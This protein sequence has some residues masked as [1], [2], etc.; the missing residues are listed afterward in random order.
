MIEYG[1]IPLVILL[2]LI[3]AV[4]TVFNLKVA[5]GLHYAATAV[6]GLVMLIFVFLFL[7]NN[8]DFWVVFSNSSRDLFIGYKLMA[9]FTTVEG[10]LLGMLF[11]MNL[12]WALGGR[13]IKG[14]EYMES[15]VLTMVTLISVLLLVVVVYINP[16]EHTSEAF[17]RHFSDGGGLA[18]GFRS[19]WMIVQPA[20]FIIGAGLG[21]LLFCVGISPILSRDIERFPHRF[22]R[23]TALTALGF[24]LLAVVLWAAWAHMSWG[25]T[26]WSF[27]AYEG[28]MVM[29][30]LFLVGAVHAPLI[31]RKGGLPRSFNLFLLIPFISFL[32][33]AYLI[34]SGKWE[35]AMERDLLSK[36]FGSPLDASWLI[37]T[38]AF[39]IMLGGAWTVVTNL[40]KD[41]PLDDSKGNNKPKKIEEKILLALPFI[42]AALGLF[43]YISVAADQ[44][45]L[46]IGMQV[47]ILIFLLVTGIVFL[48]YF[49][50]NPCPV[51]I[52]VHSVLPA[53]AIIFTL[54]TLIDRTLIIADFLLLS[55]LLAASVAAL[56]IIYLGFREI[57]TLAASG[58]NG[59]GD[60][61]LSFKKQ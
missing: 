47:I 36:W 17:T 57:R 38:L 29:V 21:G 59:P 3:S 37:L 34:W 46:R 30:L 25:Q 23:A 32:M 35:T 27:D 26:G 8:F 58:E 10:Q 7:S 55:S 14:E 15:K 42:C 53:S 56:G 45:V 48:L 33:G 44:D 24:Q 6:L 31:A 5:R 61:S 49:R 43:T 28:V 2:L 60:C 9:F 11:V 51:I 54:Y 4:S 22:L 40:F 20:A 12:S 1:L 13:L 16:F 50:S 19:P 41:D 52:G 18:D 39:L